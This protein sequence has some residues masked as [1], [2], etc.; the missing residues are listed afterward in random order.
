MEYLILALLISQA[1]IWRAAYRLWK[2]G[3]KVD[4]QTLQALLQLVDQLSKQNRELVQVVYS[5]EVERSALAVL[6]SQREG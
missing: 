1:L 6:L 5:L 3:P 2:R 4:P